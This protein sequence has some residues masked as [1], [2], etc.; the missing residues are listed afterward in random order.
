[1][2]ALKPYVVLV[3]SLV[4][5]TAC[6]AAPTQSA[7]DRKIAKITAEMQQLEAQV[8]SLKAQQ[9][10]PRPQNL[11]RHRFMRSSTAAAKPA[12]STKKTQ[13]DLTANRFLR[14][15]TVT[16]SP[17]FGANTAYDASDLLYEISSMNEDMTL[18]QHR[19]NLEQALSKVGDTLDNRALI[20]ISGGV[21]GQVLYND[22]FTGS[23]NG[24]VNLSTA[25]L[26]VVPMVSTWA[27]AFFSL[28]Y[29]TS[30]ASTG[31]RNPRGEVYLKR[32]FLT[33]GNL[34]RSP[35]YFSIGQMYAPY[36]R[37]SSAL[38]TAPLTLSMMRILA[39][40]VRLGFFYNGFYGAL[41]GFDGD[42]NT[43]NNFIREGGVNLGYKN[44]TSFGHV[45]GG[46]G[47]VT[48]IAD[49]Q[50]MQNNG[51]SVNNNSNGVSTQFGGFG[52]TV[53]VNNQP[54]NNLS[55]SVAGADSHLEVGVGNW[56][57]IG[58]Y[59]TA[60]QRFAA[61][62]MTFNFQ[63]ARPAAMHTEVDYTW[64]Y[65]GKPWTLGAAYG[66]SWQGL[67]LNLPQHSYWVLLST[68]LWKD[69]VESIEYRHD[70]NYAVQ[71]AGS[72][73]GAQIGVPDVN[74]GGT[75]NLVTA[76]VGVYF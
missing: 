57:F 9:Q 6:L 22:N 23:D 69:T 75:R 53:R 73:T 37:Y 74:V 47:Y 17:W 13:P 67:A 35:I 42:T 68:S 30:P 48:N 10:Q 63:G 27:N 46:L 26:D 49:S 44:T 60:V 45:E 61:Q 29:D 38:L 76:Q 65:D 15:V 12:A 21:E 7:T 34:D 18:L 58:E 3:A 36:G 24:S 52:Q 5:S 25:E 1:M 70:S 71:A 16:T 19:Q 54:G 50:G 55:G 72:V 62:D 51:L 28:D 8:K 66:Q 31:S 33:I 40:T 39:P 2:N 43:G 32:G 56:Y 14:G 64:H 59:M 41:Y 11:I 4:A 20:E